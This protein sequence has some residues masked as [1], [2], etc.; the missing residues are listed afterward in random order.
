MAWE[1][2]RDLARRC[3]A[4]APGAWEELASR[5]LPLVSRVAARTLARYGLPAGDAEAADLA[6]GV[7]AALL[8][9]DM[10]MLRRYAGRSA[11]GTYLSVA[12][13]RRVQ[14]LAGGQRL[15]PLEDAGPAAD[16]TPSPPEHLIREESRARLQAAVAG[17]AAR[18]RL[19][20][21]LLLREADPGEIGRILGIPPSHARTL[22]TRVR[23]RLKEALD[24][25]TSDV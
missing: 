14:R 21:A 5:M 24:Q 7:L 17:L 9:R 2:D 20:A 19:V 23:Q 12:A 8:E 15:R 13:V 1:S 25:S 22:A 6:Q 16:P 18:D 10:A 3:L 11:L 4:R